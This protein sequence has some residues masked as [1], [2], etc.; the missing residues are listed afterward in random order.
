MTNHTH[1]LVNCD[2]QV[3]PALARRIRKAA[4]VEQEVQDASTA[5]V[6]AA[7]YDP[8]ELENLRAQVRDQSDDLKERDQELTSFKAMADECATDL[9]RM[10]AQLAERDKTI[11]TLE[12]AH[13]QTIDIRGLPTEVVDDIQVLVHAIHNG[14][15]AKSAFLAVANYDRAAVDDAM[16]S[17]ADLKTHLADLERRVIPLDV[18]LAEGGIKAWLLRRILGL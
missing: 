15:E 16:L 2:V 11:E 14:N 12:H 10:R 8:D 13:Q 5:L 1:E 18:S 7:G 17:I 9:T 6:I 3:T 4:T